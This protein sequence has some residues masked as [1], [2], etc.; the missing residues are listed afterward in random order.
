[1]QEGE[2]RLLA[3]AEGRAEGGSGHGGRRVTHER[4]HALAHGVGGVSVLTDKAG[5]EGRALVDAQPKAERRRARGGAVLDA[6]L[7]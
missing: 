3:D 7:E 1:M 5:E 6:E 2:E 4:E